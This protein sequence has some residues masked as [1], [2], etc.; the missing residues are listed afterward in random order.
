[1]TSYT[2][3]CVWVQNNIIHSICKEIEYIQNIDEY[4][5]FKCLYPFAYSYTKHIYT[6]VVHIEFDSEKSIYCN[7]TIRVSSKNV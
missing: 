1:M 3:C 4:S 2:V 7:Y 6:Y 5:F